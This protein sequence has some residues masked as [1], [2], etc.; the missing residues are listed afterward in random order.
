MTTNGWNYLLWGTLIFVAS[1]ILSA[2]IV[3]LVLVKLP[4]TYFLDRPRRQL[5]ID[6]HPA[7]RLILHLLKNLLGLSLI[8]AGILLSVP[9][10]PGQGI[11]TIVIGIM[12]LDFPGKLR[13]E[14]KIVSHPRVCGTINRIRQAFGQPP[15]Q[16]SLDKTAS[17]SEDGN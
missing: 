15:L 3:G 10:I 7:I 5:W 9:G 2:V 8:V 4:S 1:V 16:L 17:S 6:H 14:R 11:L 13:W 12:L